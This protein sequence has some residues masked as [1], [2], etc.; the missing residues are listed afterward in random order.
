MPEYIPQG[1]AL[2]AEEREGIWKSLDGM[3]DWEQRHA[4]WIMATLGAVD[5]DGKANPRLEQLPP[6]EP[7]TIW[8]LQGGRGSGKTRPGA[9]TVS[10]WARKQPKARISLVAATYADFRDTMMEGESGLLNVLPP[11]A[12][13]EG[14]LAASWNRSIGEFYFSNGSRVDGYSSEKPGSLRGPQAHKVWVDEPAEFKDAH[15]GMLRDSTWSNMMFGL[16]LGEHPQVIVTGTPKDVALIHEL[17][18]HPRCFFTRFSTYRNLRNL[19]PSFAAEILSQYEGTTLGLQELHAEMIGETEGALWTKAII[20]AHRL[21]ETDEEGSLVLPKMRARA[22][23]LDPSLG[24]TAGI[25]V[26]GATPDGRGIVLDDRSV[27]GRSAVWARAAVEA[28]NDWDCHALVAE[29]NLPPIQEVIDT[30]RSVPGGD[31]VRIIPVTA[32]EGKAARAGPV[33]ALQQQGRIWFAGSFGHLEQQLVTWVPPTG[34]EPS[35]WSPD[36]LDA[37]VYSIVHLLVRHPHRRG[38]STRVSDQR[39]PPMRDRAPF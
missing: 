39:I 13:R 23:G 21:Y 1:T 28:Y 19:A 15:K 22:V 16:R 25:V 34:I 35:D 26:C 30:I 4:A 36:R 24:R 20:D 8:F 14:S 5:S 9:E 12:M 11:S 6:P 10:E 18:N 2:T 32:R 17:H 37:F 38:R 29:T 3:D 31:R 27:E 33:V 7:W